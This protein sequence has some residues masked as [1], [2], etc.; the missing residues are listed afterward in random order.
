MKWYDF[1]LYY[2]L[3][4]VTCV[5]YTLAQL[6]NDI[7]IYVGVEHIA[8]AYYPFPQ[9]IDLAYEIKPISNRIFNFVLYKI[10]S[11]LFD[12]PILFG[13]A[14]KTVML[15]IILLTSYYFA[16]KIDMRYGFL[17]TFLSLALVGNFCIGQAEYWAVVFSLWAIAFLLTEKWYLW[18]LAGLL[19]PWISLFKGITGLMLVVILCSVYL[20][21]HK[22]PD[23]VRYLA[24]F[25]GMTV[26]GFVWVGTAL[27]LWTR[28]FSDIMISPHIARVGQF[29]LW[30]YG[31]SCIGYL[32]WTWIWIPII[33]PGVFFALVYCFRAYRI[34]WKYLAAFLLM[35]LAPLFAVFCQGEFFT[36]QYYPLTVPALVTIVLWGKGK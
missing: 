10:C 29:A 23:W 35:W 5:S 28:Q 14:F 20:L 8:D 17:L 33:L 3:F 6:T 9:G 31:L 32:M 1:I 26:G 25:F 27:F 30:Q 16:S 18:I 15:I 13:I 11:S 22:D 34:G 2:I 12:N 19:A 4:P 7:R 24:W 36:Y 21:K